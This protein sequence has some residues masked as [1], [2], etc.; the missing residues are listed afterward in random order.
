[1]RKKVHISFIITV[2]FVMFLIGCTNKA[3]KNIHLH[4]LN[5]VDVELMKED[6]NDEEDMIIADEETINLLR[7][8]F[9][10]INWEPDG[11]PSMERK[12]DV[13]ATLFFEDDADMPERLVE[14]QIWFH[15][16]DTATIISNYGNENY[17]TLEKGNGQALDKLLLNK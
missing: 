13:K 2:I 7:Q 3:T 8:M 10:K 16:D 12:E 1:M 9:S 6:G 4:Q 11:Q 17:G 14:Y 15:P 5:R